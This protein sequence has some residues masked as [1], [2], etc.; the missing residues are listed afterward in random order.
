M[1][2]QVPLTAETNW[3]PILVVIFFTLFLAASAVPPDA[4]T[5]GAFAL[6]CLIN[7][8]HLIK[9][10]MQH[11]FSWRL[12]RSLCFGFCGIGKRDLVF[13]ALIQAHL[14][15]SDTLD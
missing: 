3:R 5:L 6:P 7:R 1:N 9:R 14:D 13:S 15:A 10:I 4:A 12:V 8:L 2:R 11:C